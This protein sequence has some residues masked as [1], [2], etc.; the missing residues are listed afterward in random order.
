MPERLLLYAAYDNG[1]VSGMS[2][3]DGLAV[4]VISKLIYYTDTRQHS[5]GVISYD[6]RL[7]K[8]LLTQIDHPLLVSPRGIVLDTTAG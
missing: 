3:V 1:G 8:T 2:R 6:G 7:D 4:D 5:I